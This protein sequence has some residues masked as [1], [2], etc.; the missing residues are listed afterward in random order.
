VKYLLLYLLL[1][2]P[3]ISVKTSYSLSGDF[4]YSVFLN[5][6]FG[7]S[8]A[9]III[10]YFLAGIGLRY[11][12]RPSKGFGP[13]VGYLK[14]LLPLI[15]FML[16]SGFFYNL[17]ADFYLKP[18]LYDLKWV[19]YLLAGGMLPSMLSENSKAMRVGWVL[20]MLLI[21]SLADILFVE[22][23]DCCHELPTFLDLPPLVEILPTFILILGAAAF[24]PLISWSV[25]AIQFLN[26]ANT[27]ALNQIYLSLVAVGI[28]AL[29]RKWLPKAIPLLFFNVCFLVVPIILI[30]YGGFLSDFKSD[31]VTTRTVQLE[32]LKV[33]L[34]NKGY[35]VFGMGYGATYK[36]YVKTPESDIYAVGKSITGDQESS[37]SS[38]VKFIFNTPAAGSIYKYGAVGLIWLFFVMLKI[39]KKYNLTGWR[40]AL[41]Y[42]LYLVMLFPGFLKL[43]FVVGYL[44]ALELSK[45]R[46][47]RRTPDAICSLGPRASESTPERKNFRLAL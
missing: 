21:S 16:A 17:A 47:A 19:M 7:L 38:Q 43:T 34:E 5:K 22:L 2:S 36:E 41:L 20:M 25:I 8:V 40:L 6:V 4:H 46:V 14:H 11:L 1:L 37:M 32:N 13:S 39:Q 26:M 45:A 12:N 24:N 3:E 33:N 42:F 23:F 30:V 10:L 27:L 9:D 28:I 31:G 44:L 15:A 29:S 18:F 35:G